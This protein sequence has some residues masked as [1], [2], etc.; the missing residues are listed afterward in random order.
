MTAQSSAEQSL[1]EQAHALRFDSDDPYDFSGHD[2]PNPLSAIS[3]TPSLPLQ[4]SLDPH[5]SSAPTVPKF[6]S[7]QDLLDSTSKLTTQAKASTSSFISTSIFPSISCLA[8]LGAQFL[9]PQN[10]RQALMS[11]QIH[12]WKKTMEREYESLEANNT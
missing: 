7:I 8:S 12:E 6:R 4:P 3:P 2:F 1:D 9:E 10:Y 5:V 11:D